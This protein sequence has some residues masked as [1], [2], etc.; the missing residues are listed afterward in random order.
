MIALMGSL[1]LVIQ[2]RGARVRLA[3][4]ACIGLAAYIW[5]I[6]MFRSTLATL[7][8]SLILYP[9][10]LSQRSRIKLVVVLSP[11]AL[12]LLPAVIIFASDYFLAA[13]GGSIRAKA[14]A[15]AV[16]H[17]AHHPFLGA[18]EDSAYGQSYQD[19]VAPYFF[20]SDLGLVGITYKYGIL[21][22]LLYLFMH[23]KIWRRLWA[24]NLHWR[25]QNGRIE[26]LLWGML[27]F[28]TAQTF[29]LALN[30]GLAYAQGITAG[31]LALALASLHL[32]TPAQ[33]GE[34]MAGV[35]RT[36]SRSIL[37]APTSN[38]APVA[39]GA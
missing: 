6:V 18:G 34:K 25:E 21:G 27:L 16:E 4:I 2:R 23:G 8:L 35:A 7:L 26:P 28:M 9:V 38:P 33:A 37:L 17:I 19:I 39:T 29:N 1:A 12:L 13:D 11:L 3:A 22:V 5:S 24:A 36:A 14:F 30:P 31:S 32:P 10:L 15:L 20:P